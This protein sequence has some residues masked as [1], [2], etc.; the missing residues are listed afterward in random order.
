MIL[1]Y[2]PLILK[3]HCDDLLF[4]VRLFF[5][6]VWKLSKYRVIF[7]P[8]F[9]VFSP[10]KGKYGPEKTPYL[11][12]FHAVWDDKVL[13]WKINLFPCKLLSLLKKPL[14]SKTVKPSSIIRW[15]YCCWKLTQINWFSIKIILYLLQQPLY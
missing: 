10:N 14:I 12:T 6:N 5:V 11:D 2:R 8:Y 7:G 9:P 1:E 4:L 13:S 15:C 3:E